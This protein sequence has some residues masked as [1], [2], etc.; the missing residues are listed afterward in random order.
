MPYTYRTSIN[1]SLETVFET[2]GN[3]QEFSESGPANRED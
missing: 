3:P 1:S 2:V